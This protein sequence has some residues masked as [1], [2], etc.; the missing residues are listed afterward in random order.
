M[1]FNSNLGGGAEDDDEFEEDVEKDDDKAVC[2]SPC[3]CKGC[4]WCDW[5]VGTYMP[6]VCVVLRNGKFTVPNAKAACMFLCIHILL[7]QLNFMDSLTF[8]FISSLIT[9]SSSL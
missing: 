6:G 5:F 3:C 8:P 7:A 2:C 1:S 9:F 4:R